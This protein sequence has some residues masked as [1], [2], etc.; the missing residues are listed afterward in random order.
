M[1]YLKDKIKR[2]VYQELNKVKEDREFYMLLGFM[3]KCF[4]YFAAKIQCQI[5]SRTIY[6][7][8]D[9]KNIK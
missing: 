5:T 6:E 8:F 2:S 1:S 9:A 4:N 3:Y 7:Y